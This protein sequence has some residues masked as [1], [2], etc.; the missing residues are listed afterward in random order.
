MST[1]LSTSVLYETAVHAPRDK[2]Q[3]FDLLEVEILRVTGD[4][5][6]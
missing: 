6:L 1:C 4:G 5:F 2:F 3:A